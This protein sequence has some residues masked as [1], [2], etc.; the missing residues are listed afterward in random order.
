[1]ILAARL[2]TPEDFGLVGLAQ[3]FLGLI[4]MIGEFGMATAI[5]AQPNLDDEQIGQLNAVA[6]LVGIG[7]VVVTCAAAIPLGAFFDAPKLPWVVVATSSVFFITSLRLVPAALL[8]RGFAFRFLALTE[9]AQA[10][11]AAATM[12]AMA[13]LGLGY[14]ALV[15]A[16]IVG[17]LVATTLVMSARRCGFIRPRAA[18]VAGIVSDGR[19]LLTGRLS[20][21]VQTNADLIIIGRVL[22]NAA[23]GSYTLAMSI[24]SLPM[25]KITSVVSQVSP[26]FIAATRDKPEKTREI[27]LILTAVLA[28]VVFPVSA[29][30]AMVAEEF[31][32][33][34]LGP[35]WVDAIVPL[36]LLAILAAARSIM[37]VLA[38]VVLLT[39]GIRFSMYM[40]ITEACVMT[41]IFYGASRYGLTGIAIGSIVAYPFLRAPFCWIAFRRLNLTLGHYIEALWPALRATG[42]MVVAVGAVDYFLPPTTRPVIGLIA[43]IVTGMVVYAAASLAQRPRLLALYR[44]FRAL[45]RPTSTTAESSPAGSPT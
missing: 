32:S 6:G 21:W 41:A 45:G 36:Q 33:F 43:Q 38:T 10:I 37:S 44:S 42:A 9:S 24:A 13:A 27:L 18:R 31:V 7:A 26:P 20:W 1:M 34:A 28:I 11:A 5:I 25:E 8:Q 19:R 35:K 29:G 23:L 12:V 4:S 22:G 16:P 2:L 40:G 15:L 3:V 17:N 39:G 14:W 30:L